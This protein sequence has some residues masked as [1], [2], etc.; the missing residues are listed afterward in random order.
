MAGCGLSGASNHSPRTGHALQGA[1]FTMRGTLTIGS[2]SR[3]HTYGFALDVLYNA[4]K[5]PITFESA[6]VDNIPTGLHFVRMGL[7]NAK[8]TDGTVM[9][10]TDTDWKGSA[11]TGTDY[12]KFPN[13]YGKPIVIKPVTKTEPLYYPVVFVRF[14]SRHGETLTMHDCTIF[15]KQGNAHYKQHQHCQFK[16]TSQQLPGG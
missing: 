6:K 2:A 12:G 7:Y 14:D 15:Y 5:T 9:G 16:I 11:K 8:E 3:G 4:S 10:G 13:H 1:G